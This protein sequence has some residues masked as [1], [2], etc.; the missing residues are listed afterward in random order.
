[1]TYAKF[2]EKPIC[3]ECGTWKCSSCGW[4][5]TNANRKYPPGQYCHKCQSRKGEML[6]VR[7]SAPQKCSAYDP[8]YPYVLP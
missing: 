5:R 1:M 8:P 6:P 7:H 2:P 4:K 3:E